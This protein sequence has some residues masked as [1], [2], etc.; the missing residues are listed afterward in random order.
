RAREADVLLIGRALDHDAA[1]GDEDGV[2]REDAG[3]GAAGRGRAEYGAVDGDQVGGGVAG[4][5]DVAGVARDGDR[6]G[7]GRGGGRAGVA[8]VGGRR[9]RPR[10]ARVAR[11]GR[12]VGGDVGPTAVSAVGVGRRRRVAPGRGAHDEEGRAT[13]DGGADGDDAAVAGDGRGRAAAAA[14]AAG[15]RAANDAGGQ[16]SVAGRG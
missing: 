12:G 1:S 15:D 13:R 7:L 9:L 6:A 5:A 16:R 10:Q 11:D 3:D 8:P 14:V 2:A 4:G